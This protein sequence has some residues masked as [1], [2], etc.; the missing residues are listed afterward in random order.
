VVAVGCGPADESE[1]GSTSD[2]C[3]ACPFEPIVDDAVSV[4]EQQVHDCGT[5]TWEDD[6]AAWTA[7]YDC[8]LADLQTQTAVVVR[9]TPMVIDSVHYR[10]IVGAAAE[11]YAMTE[12]DWDCYQ[13][14]VG[15]SQRPCDAVT[16]TPGCTV[17]V[18]DLCLVCEGGALTT[19]CE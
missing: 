7:A 11:S 12:I 13:G 9:W 8:V 2:A 19:I 5:V 17:E 16:P 6:V 4:S 14:D 15:A 10:A 3:E 18:G 1:D